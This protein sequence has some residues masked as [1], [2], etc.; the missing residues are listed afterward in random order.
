MADDLIDQYK[1]DSLEDIREALKKGRRG[2]YGNNYGKLNMIVISGWM[3]LHLEEKAKAREA[4]IQKQKALHNQDHSGDRLIDIICNR[5]D[6]LR[7]MMKEGKPRAELDKEFSEIQKLK[8]QLKEN[9]KSFLSKEKKGKEED[10]GFNEFKRKREEDPKQLRLN[11]L[12]ALAKHE[13]EESL[14]YLISQLDDCDDRQIYKE[15]LKRRENEQS[16]HKKHQEAS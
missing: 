16:K 1:T 14:M 3:K 2:H 12:R 10:Q 15:E 8:D 13:N 9:T 4:Q 11:Q 7:Q 5:E 6:N